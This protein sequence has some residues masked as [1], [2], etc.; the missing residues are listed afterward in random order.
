MPTDLERKI[1]LEIARAQGRIEGL[2]QALLLA[3]TAPALPAPDPAPAAR[4]VKPRSVVTGDTERR[5]LAVARWLLEHGPSKPRQICR[6][7]DIPPGSLNRIFDCPWF[8]RVPGEHGVWRLTA[9]GRQAAGE[10]VPERNGH[11]GPKERERHSG[12]ADQALDALGEQ[13]ANHLPL[14]ERPPLAAVLG[15]DPEG[16]DALRRKSARMCRAHGS[17]T[18]AG[19]REVLKVDAEEIEDALSCE[20]FRKIGGRYGMT[21]KG[22][23]TL[24]EE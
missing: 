6:G 22:N 19:L 11:A 16:L 17:S 3:G 9:E 23:N 5:R 14:D 18:I 24:L 15:Y 12:I 1:E 4:P 7:L 2:Q 13:A 10:R 21:P 20:Y 8:E